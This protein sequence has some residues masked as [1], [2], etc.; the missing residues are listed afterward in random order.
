MAGLFSPLRQREVLLLFGA[1]I[2]S[3]FGDWA[4]RIA[5][6]VIVFDRSDSVVWAALVTAVSLLPWVGPGQL[7][8][9]F[10]DRLGRLTVMV[11]SDLLR[12]GIFL[13]LLV[14]PPLAV[15]L[16]LAFAAGMLTPAF[17]AARSAAM[18]DVTEPDMYGR[19]LKLWGATVQFEAMV[20]F[21]IGGVVVTTVGVPAAII[22]NAGTFVVS[23]VLLLP[24]SGTAAAGRHE[25]ARVG[26][27]GLSDGVRVWRTDPYLTRS[28]MMFVVVGAFSILPEALAVPLVAESNLPDAFVAVVLA[29]GAGMSMIVMA[30]LPDLDDDAALIR[31]AGVRTARYAIVASALYAIVAL[32]A[33]SSRSDSS[34]AVAALPAV[35]AISAYA[36]A[37]GIDAIGVPTNQVVGRRLPATGR[38]GA[39]AVGMG[40]GYGAQALMIVIVGSIAAATSVAA[41]LAG[42]LFIAAASSVWFARRPVDRPPAGRDHARLTRSSQSSEK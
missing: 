28:L 37:G 34:F 11:G 1:Q 33:T 25:H 2:A 29:A 20:G 12:A 22:F 42:A 24:L 3:G 23:A 40:A 4:G 9:T 36:V 15:T 10:A 19:A 8:A 6:T 32:L 41:V 35:V 14:T 16:M 31:T 5:I 13:V 18:V 17:A 21:A 30:R 7:L 39:M 38:A 27:G 26:F